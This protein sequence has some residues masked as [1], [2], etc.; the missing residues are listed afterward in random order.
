MQKFPPH[1]AIIRVALKN[2]SKMQNYGQKSFKTRLFSKLV[3]F[4][5]Q[6]FNENQENIKK[7]ALIYAN[8]SKIG[9]AY[10]SVSCWLHG[11]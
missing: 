11:G 6:E 5:L 9:N 10:A 8:L 3:S 4:F 1:Y 7:S 2:V